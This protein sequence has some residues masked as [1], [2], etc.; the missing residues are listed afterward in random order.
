MRRE[1]KEQIREEEKRMMEDLNLGFY[2]NAEEMANKYEEMW[3]ET[4]F[5]RRYRERLEVVEQ[6]HNKN[7]WNK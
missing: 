1:E 4:K 5:L 3:G 2:D 6:A 7:D